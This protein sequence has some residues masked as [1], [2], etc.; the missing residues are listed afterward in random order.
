MQFDVRRVVYSAALAAAICGSIATTAWAQSVPRPNIPATPQELQRAQPQA[1]F[2]PP[3]APSVDSSGALA[4]NRC[5]A[6][7]ETSSLTV[8][9][10]GVDYIGPNGQPVPPEILRVVAPLSAKLNGQPLSGSAQPIRVVCD[11]RDQTEVALRKAGFI[12]AVQVPQQAIANSSGRL[13]LTIVTAKIV[14]LRVRGKPGRN[15]DRIAKLLERLKTLDPLNEHDAER[16]LLLARD[17]PGVNLSLVLRPAGTAPGEIIGEVS[18]ETESGAVFAGINDLGSTEIGRWGGLLRGEAYGLLGL[19][20][21]AYIGY[22]GTADFQEQRVVQAGYDALAG[23][24]DLRLSTQITY[25]VSKPT[26][27]S[28]GKFLPLE[29]KSLI[30]SFGGSYPLVRSV[31]KNLRISG[32][33]ELVDQNIEIDATPLN[34]DKLRLLTLRLDGDLTERSG[35]LPPRYHFV[36]GAEMDQGLDILGASQTGLDHDPLDPGGY[37]TRFYGDPTAFVLSGSLLSEVR[38]RFG[39]GQKY[40]VT[41]SV[42][43]QGQWANNPLMAFQEFAV[44]NLTLGRGYDPGAVSG[45]N[46]IG[47]AFELR[48]GKPQVNSVKD[49]AFEAFGFYDA[50]KLWNLDP[51]PTINNRTFASYGAGVR[52]TWGDHGRIDLVYAHPLD[53]TYDV[54][55]PPPPDRLLVTLTLR[56][57]PWRTGQ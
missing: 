24:S 44:G 37:P 19:A 20:D 27:E 25:S 18:L 31:A 16:V 56:A 15:R 9:L 57:W 7:L 23:N 43:A 49:V 54:S 28:G 34:E 2:S 8:P 33:F 48:V 53:P 47:A 26:I 35:L 36:V 10:V 29:S 55:Q 4:Q 38:A 17:I 21:R 51:S 42:N 52:V 45:D 6:A 14:E 1:P 32:G 41:F 50:V 40:A 39:N 30:W 3:S 12:A 5:P 13:K 46:A 22:F 11:L